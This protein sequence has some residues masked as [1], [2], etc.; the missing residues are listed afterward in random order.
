MNNFFQFIK[1][2]LCNYNDYKIIIESKYKKKNS[3]EYL[4]KLFLSSGSQFMDQ[5]VKCNRCS[6]IYTNPRIKENI[7]NKG[8]SFSID[9]KFISQDQ[10]RIKSFENT[11][12]TINKKINLSKKKILDVGSASGAFLKACLNK[13]INA[14]GIEPN[15]WLVDFGK[16]NYLVNIKNIRLNKVNKKYDVVSFFDVIEHVPNLKK[17]LLDI[18]K[19]TK[20]NGYLIITVPDHDSYARK[21][22]A[23]KWPFYLNVHVHYFTKDTLIKLFGSKYSLIYHKSYW[24]TL[25]LSYVLNRATQIFKIFKIFQ[26]LTNILGLGKMSIKYNMGQTL[27]IFKKK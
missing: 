27:F 22:L 16:R 4:R 24:P 3:Y 26:V 10:I 9:K 17:I 23:K 12:D 21:I 8:Y 2:P 1:C 14:D 5:V 13:N 7:I 11:I 19:V 25:Q 6:L 15:K 20:K 18:N